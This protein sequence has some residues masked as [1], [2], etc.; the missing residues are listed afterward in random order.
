MF[1]RNKLITFL[2]RLCWNELLKSSIRLRLDTSLLKMVTVPMRMENFTEHSTSFTWDGIENMG[3]Q[4]SYSSIA[5]GTGVLRFIVDPSVVTGHRKLNF[6]NIDKK[7]GLVLPII[8]YTHS[9]H[10]LLFLMH[11]LKQIIHSNDLRLP[12]SS[13]DF[14]E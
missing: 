14:C 13:Y 1:Y 9:S 3:V 11:I 6:N 10:F 8:T 5:C 2:Y 7:D 4:G 12:E